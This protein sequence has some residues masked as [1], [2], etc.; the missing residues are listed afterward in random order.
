MTNTLNLRI[1]NPTPEEVTEI[2][3]KFALP[4]NAPGLSQIV[5]KLEPYIRQFWDGPLDYYS[6]DHVYI[7]GPISG[8][9][10][11]NRQ[12]FRRAENVINNLYG[13]AINP[14][15]LDLDEGATWEECMRKCLTMLCV[16]KAIALLPGW[17]DSRGAKVEYQTAITLGMPVYH[18]TGDYF[19]PTPETTQKETRP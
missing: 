12:A 8:M 7:A 5:E 9:K 1:D 15:C 17:E 16:C 13:R 18:L 11:D 6:S 14:A 3:K 2:Y 4:N 10:D 19:A